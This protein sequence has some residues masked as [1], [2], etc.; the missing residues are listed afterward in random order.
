MSFRGEFRW[1]IV[2]DEQFF[3]H[4]EVQMLS[5]KVGQLF[6]LLYADAY[7]TPSRDIGGELPMGRVRAKP[8]T[9]S[10]I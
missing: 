8:L 7:G 2:F 1:H 10:R 6:R 4:A 5:N 3:D 9:L